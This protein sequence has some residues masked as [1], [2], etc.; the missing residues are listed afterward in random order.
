[1]R[2]VKIIPP[3]SFI[4]RNSFHSSIVAQFR[5]CSAPNC[6]QFMNNSQMCMLYFLNGYDKESRIGTERNRIMKRHTIIVAT[7]V[8]LLIGCSNRSIVTD[9]EV[10]TAVKESNYPFTSLSLIIDT[11]RMANALTIQFDEGTKQLEARYEN[12]E[13]EIFL[14]GNKAMKKIEELF[15]NWEID[16]EMRE[17]DLVKAAADAVEMKEYKVLKLTIEF[18]GYN[19]KKI[20]FSKS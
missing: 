15:T 17:E 18:K 1:M 6:I 9:K 12:K 13:E 4:L 8:L 10:Q 3:T 11:D 16:P 20:T 2:I 14:H 7:I 5:L 19:P